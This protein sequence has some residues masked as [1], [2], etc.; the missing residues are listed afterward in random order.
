L[1]GGATELVERLDSGDVVKSPWKGRPTT[2]DCRQEMAIE[3]QI[4]ERLGAHAQLVQ[5]KCWDPVGHA[6]TL[7]YMPKSNL[8]EYVQ[9]YRQ[10]VLPSQRQQ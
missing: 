3:A 2:S 10:E 6:L 9:K 5:S 7:E 1:S 8:K 4:Y